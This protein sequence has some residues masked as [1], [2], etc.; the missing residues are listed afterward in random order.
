MPSGVNA[1]GFFT[2]TSSFQSRPISGAG[3]RP[4]SALQWLGY[5]NAVCRFKPTTSIGADSSSVTSGSALP[6]TF[7]SNHDIAR[8]IN[9]I[10]FTS[11]PR[12]PGSTPKAM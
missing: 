12:V 10:H 7:T 9:R 11:P 1:A 2:S 4:S 6:A 5:W 3:P 8:T